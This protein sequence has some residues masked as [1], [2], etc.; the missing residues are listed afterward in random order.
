MLAFAIVFVVGRWMLRPLFH[1]VAAGRSGEL[2]TL[3]VLLDL[4][5]L[6]RIWR[7]AMLGAAVLM[8][9]KVAL[10][11]ALVRIAGSDARTALRTALLLAVGGAPGTRA[12]W[13][14]SARRAPWRS[15]RRRSRRR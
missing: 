1:A 12:T 4:T 14:R 8:L 13:R 6:P 3:A 15:C 5:A 10:V 9:V 2:F 11:A 7:Q